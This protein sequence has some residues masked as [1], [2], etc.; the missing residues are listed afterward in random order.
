M[1]Q[2]RASI[3]VTEQQKFAVLEAI[4][5]ISAQ[6]D[7]LVSLDQGERRTLSTMGPK[8]ERFARGV[9]RVLQENDVLVA[10][11]MNLPE[12]VGDL[13]AFDNLLP[14][15]DALMALVSRVDDTTA[16]LGSDVM[17]FSQYGYGMLK[18]HGKSQGLEDMLKELSYRYQRPSR[19]NSGNVES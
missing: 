3:R 16:A 18:L 10:P 13:E 17:S 12:A 4:G 2:N 8:S 14:I 7:G 15:R 19:K 5:Q 11:V 1:S 9:L 6:L